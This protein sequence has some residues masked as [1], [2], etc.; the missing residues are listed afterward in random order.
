MLGFLIMLNVILM[1]LCIVFII[2]LKT[3][4]PIKSKRKSKNIL[5]KLCIILSLIM[6]ISSLYTGFR[7]SGQKI[8]LEYDL[9]NDANDENNEA[10]KNKSD[11]SNRLSFK[12][13]II[14]SLKDIDKAKNKLAAYTILSYGLY[15]MAYFLEKSVENE[16][17]NRYIG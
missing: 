4:N 15:L 16:D 8:I 14:E 10:A 13:L 11:Y 6:C 17:R 7:I 3:I 12:D 2:K 9:S 1:L 5:I